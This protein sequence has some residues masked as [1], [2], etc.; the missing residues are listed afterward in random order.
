MKDKC[1]EQQEYI[2]SAQIFPIMTN[3]DRTKKDD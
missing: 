1:F 3:E 2:K